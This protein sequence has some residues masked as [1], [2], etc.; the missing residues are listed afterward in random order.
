VF[1]RAIDGLKRHGIY[2]YVPSLLRHF[3]TAQ[4][5]TL[6]APRPHIAVAGSLDA[7]TPP[8]GLDR[9]DN[10]PRSMRIPARPRTGSCYASSIKHKR[11]PT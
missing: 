1:W 11:N 5:N 8:A 9:I 10:K 2:Y 7:I 4:I 6:I 3:T